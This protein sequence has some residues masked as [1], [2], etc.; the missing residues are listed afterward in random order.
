MDVFPLKE[1]KSSRTMLF[2]P[3]FVII[4]LASLFFLLFSVGIQ[5]KTGISGKTKED[6]GRKL[7]LKRIEVQNLV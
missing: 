6:Q 1:A 7:M 5:D 2:V 3:I 4:N